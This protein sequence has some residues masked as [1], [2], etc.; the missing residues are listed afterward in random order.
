MQRHLCQR[1][2]EAL[3][4]KTL[5]LRRECMGYAL[6]ASSLLPGVSTCHD[7]DADNGLDRSTTMCSTPHLPCSS[8]SHARH[9]YS[10]CSAGVSKAPDGSFWVAHRGDRVRDAAADEADGAG[11]SVGLPKA[12][13][14][15]QAAVPVQGPTLLRI[16]ADTGAVLQVRD[17][18][19]PAQET[20]HCSHV[21]H[22]YRL[23]KG[24]VM[25]TADKRAAL[26]TFETPANKSVAGQ[27]ILSLQKRRGIRLD[28][29]P[30]T[31]VGPRPAGNAAR[32]CRGCGGRR[33]GHGSC[34]APGKSCCMAR[35]YLEANSAK[36]NNT[37]DDVHRKAVCKPTNWFLDQCVQHRQRMEPC[38][39]CLCALPC[40]HHQRSARFWVFVSCDY[41]GTT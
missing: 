38:V 24:H 40:L 19:S 8:M 35:S 3:H 15:A 25:Y 27:L 33:L 1:R 30:T 29:P 41:I 17:A 36:L 23:S 13:A 10:V 5:R 16:E 6:A 28:Q 31:G 7:I 37:I 21:H 32:P 12:E 14:Q 11:R 18:S 2:P 9:F 26:I 22:P 34:Q 39:Q 4:Y 20:P